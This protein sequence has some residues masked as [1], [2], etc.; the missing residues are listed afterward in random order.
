MLVAG[1]RPSENGLVNFAAVSEAM[2]SQWQGEEEG[3]CRSRGSGPARLTSGGTG[4]R[5]HAVAGAEAE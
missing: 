1:V 4:Q 2:E 5:R 3:G